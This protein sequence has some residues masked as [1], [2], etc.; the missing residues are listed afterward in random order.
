MHPRRGCK[1]PRAT[2]GIFRRRSPAP[3]GGL[4]IVAPI[5]RRDER[6]GN[7]SAAMW[8][9]MAMLGD[10]AMTGCIRIH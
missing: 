6:E 4:G 9:V 8:D 10:L 5:R 7:G 3:D 2:N 1:P